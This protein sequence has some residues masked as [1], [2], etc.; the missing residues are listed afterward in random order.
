MSTGEHPGIIVCV[1]DAVLDRIF[2]V[3]DFPIGEAKMR[4]A[5]SMEVGGGMAATAAVAITRL[6]GQA[7]LWSRVGED[8]A[9]TA[10]IAELKSEGVDVAGV[11]RHAG[12][13]SSVSCILVNAKG[14]R[15]IVN[16][17]GGPFPGG[18]DVAPPISVEM[19]AVVLGDTKW[20]AATAAAFRRARARGIPTLLDADVGGLE[21]FSVLLPLA[22][23][24]IFSEAALARFNE[25]ALN[26][27]LMQVVASGCSHAGVTRGPLGYQ[28]CDSSGRV[29]E[30]PAYRTA[31]VDTT[32]AGDAFH[33]A[34]AQGIAEGSSARECAHL[35]AAVAAL[36]CTKP[37]GRAGLPSRDEVDQFMQ[38]NR[39]T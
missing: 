1:G 37:G 30:V 11:E 18:S 34:F 32:G 35:A 28:W 21:V 39:E 13:R 16:D 31:V 7:H 3:E 26:V 2:F 33:G 27:A 8:T 14:Q 12:A 38:A 25:H 10:I 9:G 24:S 23:F 5:S 20:P 15:I 19:A 36:K 17:R 6:G 4:A 29:S 22:D